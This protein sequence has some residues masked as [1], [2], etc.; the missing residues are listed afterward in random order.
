MNIKSKKLTIFVCLFILSCH[1][2]GS[3]WIFLQPRQ[4]EKWML[5]T[6]VDF[7]MIWL[8]KPYL[9]S[10][11]EIEVDEFSEVHSEEI[12]LPNGEL[13]DRFCDGDNSIFT[14]TSNK[15]Y[16]YDTKNLVW[17]EIFAS[18]DILRRCKVRY[19]GN[20]F[21]IEGQNVLTDLTNEIPESI[22]FPYGTVQDFFIDKSYGMYILSGNKIYQQLDSSWIE[23]FDLHMIGALDSK[24]VFQPVESDFYYIEADNGLYR[25]AIDDKGIKS[26]FLVS[27]DYKSIKGVFQSDSK[28]VNIISENYLLEIIDNTCVMVVLPRN[29]HTIFS[30]VFDSADD[31]LY[32]STEDG[33]FYANTSDFEYNKNQSNFIETCETL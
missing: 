10:I 21:V 23:V 19:D 25:L 14:T 11:T 1:R 6:S 31:V 2:N 5:G 18:T 16:K 15:I 12:N 3:P 22:T 29:I 9:E 33:V 17:K 30:T 8:S 7:N 4:D 26:N 13:F 32:I 28:K 24:A 20:I 27:F